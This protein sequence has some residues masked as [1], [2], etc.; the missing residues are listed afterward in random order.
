MLVFQVC[1]EDLERTFIET[2]MS[3]LPYMHHGNMLPILQEDPL[4]SSES[5]EIAIPALVNKYH[6]DLCMDT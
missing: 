5:T 4:E 6:I 2:G 3:Y 1:E